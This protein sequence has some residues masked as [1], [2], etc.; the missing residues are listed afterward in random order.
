ME[1]ASAFMLGVTVTGAI[2]SVIKTVKETKEF[3]HDVKHVDETVAQFSSEM[4]D[5]ET[6]LNLIK[7][8]LQIVEKNPSNPDVIS[9]QSA[10]AKSLKGCHS[11]ASDLSAVFQSLGKRRVVKELKLRTKSVEVA[12]FRR[13]LGHYTRHLELRVSVLICEEIKLSREPSQQ[14]LKEFRAWREDWPQQ[15]AQLHTYHKDDTE[16]TQQLIET[17]S[18][19]FEE[20]PNTNPCF[21]GYV[22]RTKIGST[23]QWIETNALAGPPPSEASFPPTLAFSKSDTDDDGASFISDAATAV[24]NPII[25]VSHELMGVKFGLITEGLKHYNVD[26]FEKAQEDFRHAS[27]MGPNVSVLLFDDDMTEE[28][29]NLWVCLSTLRAARLCREPQRSSSLKQARGLLVQIVEQR[30]SSP[31]PKMHLGRHMNAILLAECHLYS[32]ALAEAEGICIAVQADIESAL[33]IEHP[34]FYKVVLTIASIHYAK[35]HTGPAL[36]WLRKLPASWLPRCVQP[37]FDRHGTGKSASDLFLLAVQKERFDVAVCMLRSTPAL[38]LST[39]GPNFLYEAAAQ[40]SLPIIT[41]LVAAGSSI[42]ARGRAD[43]KI[44]DAKGGLA[45]L[46]LKSSSGPSTADKSQNDTALFAAI[47]NDQISAVRL[48]IDLRANIESLDP[49]DSGHVYFTALGFAVFMGHKKIVK[50]LLDCGA[51]PNAQG[52]VPGIVQQPLSL[53]IDRREKWD[54]SVA[55]LLIER[56]ADLNYGWYFRRPLI[57]AIGHGITEPVTQLLAA[58]VDVNTHATEDFENAFQYQSPLHTTIVW[59]IYKRNPEIIEELLKQGADVNYTKPAF[60]PL[61]IYAITQK[62]AGLVDLL[63]RWRAK[64]NP[65]GDRQTSP[66]LEAISI[67]EPKIVH[68]LLQNGADMKRQ[69]YLGAPEY[70]NRRFSPL[71]FAQKLNRRRIRRILTKWAQK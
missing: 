10:I 71:E 36:Q 69:G 44:I 8:T 22:D 41:L 62:D 59:T 24:K 60:D 46:G 53:A 55:P 56:G 61:L 4:E 7:H 19:A 27:D 33:G 43:A 30:K 20:G 37:F 25:P 48:F 2:V 52:S 50:L 23:K 11:S 47:R 54:E 38:G 29:L 31:N 57:Q 66:L 65:Q 68:L 16:E 15:L 32:D 9:P 42:H 28:R 67:N 39:G 64:P 70:E 45:F 35:G 1:G 5:V 26:N 21:R 14:M 18:V 40:G 12:E 58:G 51:K 13:R 49:G 6:T 63:L 17:A 3:V 34:L